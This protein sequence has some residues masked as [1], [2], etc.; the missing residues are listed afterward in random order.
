[1]GNISDLISNCKK[2]LKKRK[3]KKVGYC[4]K[5][6]DC[7]KYAGGMSFDMNNIYDFEVNKRKRKQCYAF[8]HNTNKCKHHKNKKWIC[9]CWPMLPEHIEKFPRCT[10]KFEKIC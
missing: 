2:E 1:M 3:L 5:C 7:C 9:K 8:N 6:G 4:C 10:Y